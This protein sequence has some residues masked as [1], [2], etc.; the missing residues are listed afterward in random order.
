MS[1]RIALYI[2]VLTV[3]FSVSAVK[4]D[5]GKLNEF[6]AKRFVDYHAAK[7]KLQSDQINYI[8]SQGTYETRLKK[9]EQKIAHLELQIV[10]LKKRIADKH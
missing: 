9:L 5:D 6:L 3:S 8:N 1:K 2:S 4:A 10:S 7:Y